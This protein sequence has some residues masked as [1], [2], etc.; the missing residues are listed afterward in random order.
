M[1]RLLAIAMV[2]GLVAACGAETDSI[3]GDL[4]AASEVIEAPAAAME[5]VGRDRY[6]FTSANA[7]ATI[8]VFEVEAADASRFEVFSAPRD[9]VIE[10][11]RN[12]VSRGAL[13]NVLDPADSL[14]VILIPLLDPTRDFRVDFD[15]FF[16]A[17]DE[18]GAVV[19]SDY[20]E[21]TTERLDELFDLGRGSGLEPAEM[22]A[23]TARAINAESPTGLESEALAI[24]R[25]EA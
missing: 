13:A 5:P 17:L 15:A 9:D 4:A 23:L 14:V 21:T 25:G 12:P 3:E 24:L 20:S 8:D 22:L 2:T 1:R 10:F 16:I 7:E 6:G 19:A 11:V 18:S